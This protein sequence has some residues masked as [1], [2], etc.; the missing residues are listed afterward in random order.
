MSQTLD[1]I[2]HR[3]NHE[4]DMATDMDIDVAADMDVDMAIDMAVG[5]DVD[6]HDR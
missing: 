1:S 4:R 3:L 6:L 2:H 5:M